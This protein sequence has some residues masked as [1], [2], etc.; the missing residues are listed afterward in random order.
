MN[1]TTKEVMD[2]AIFFV[3]STSERYSGLD[4]SV[5]SL[6]ILDGILDDASDFFVILKES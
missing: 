2:A 3:A 6:K 5:E 4:F 1:E